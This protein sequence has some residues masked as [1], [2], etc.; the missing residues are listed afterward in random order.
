MKS[1]L[2]IL[3]LA[4]L[5]L[6]VF[7][8]IN[9]AGAEIITK[10]ME[11]KQGDAVLKGYLAYDD[12]IQGQRPGVLIIHQ[13]MGITD[14]E[15]M[16]AQK[17]AEMGYVAFAADIYGKGV[18]PQNRDE[19]AAQAG[20]YRGDR[21]LLR[22]RAN[23]GL[24]QL[25]DNELSI[26]SRLAAIGYCFGGGAVLELARSG[27]DLSGVVSFHGNLDTPDPSDARNIVCKVLVQH[28]AAD[29]HVPDKQVQALQKEMSAADVDWYMI[30]YGGAV[31]S[32]TDPNAGDDPSNGS[33]Y[34]A[35]A[36]RRSWQ[37]MQDF[38]DE[39]FE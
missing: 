29:P 3:S 18:R 25:R 5:L 14:Y 10:D 16:R 6:P 31:H 23:A 38:F 11:Y 32:F 30:S 35:K 39:L 27:A 28:G 8:S 26:D 33:A 22:A 17:L 36:D 19:A 15:K 2:H 1:I 21:Q 4:L 37:A 24:E 7:G 13:W 20:K 9:S 34:D 12:A